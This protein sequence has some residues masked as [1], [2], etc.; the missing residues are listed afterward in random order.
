MG[1]AYRS[2]RISIRGSSLLGRGAASF[3]RWKTSLPALG[4]GGASFTCWKTR[5]R[6]VFL[7]WDEALPCSSAGRQGGTSSS[8]TVMRRHL[9]LPLED[10]ATPHLPSLGRGAASFFCWKARRRLVFQRWDEVLPCSYARRRS[11]ASSSFAGM[12]RCLVLLLEGEA[13]KEDEATPCL[14]KACTGYGSNGIACPRGFQT[15]HNLWGKVFH[16]D[17]YRP[18]RAIHIGPL[19]YRYADRSLPGGTAKI[20]H[21]RSIEGEIDRRRSIEGEKR[22]NKKRKRRK[23]KRRNISR[24]PRPHVVAARG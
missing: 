16:T 14:T 2:D 12:R 23:K 22:K 18:Y 20:D 10:E 5:R 24:R 3:L 9:V 17:L 7:R 8:C 6:P 11:D 21:R 13:A 19:G 1:G 15:P 4:R